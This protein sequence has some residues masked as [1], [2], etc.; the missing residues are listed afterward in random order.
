MED[1]TAQVNSAMQ[2]STNMAYNSHHRWGDTYLDWCNR[3][4]FQLSQEESVTLMQINSMLSYLG[5]IRTKEERKARMTQCEKY[6]QFVKYELKT[7]S[8]LNPNK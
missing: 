3:E 5:A 6:D 7:I 4:K 1:A 8:L 2:R